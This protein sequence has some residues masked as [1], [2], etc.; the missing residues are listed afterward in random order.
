MR[1]IRIGAGTKM[2]KTAR[3]LRRAAKSIADLWRRHRV[4]IIYYGAV[5]AVL[6]AIALAADGYRDRRAEEIAQ[7][8]PT[9]MM[10]ASPSFLDAPAAEPEKLA[11]RLPSGA[12]ILRAFSDAPA[13]NA[14]LGQWE[15]HDGTDICY[16]NGD[17]LA[18]CAGTV[19]EI[20]Q[21]D[22]LGCTIAVRT[23]DDSIRYMGVEEPAVRAGEHVDAGER[24]AHQSDRV[25]CE[26]HLG[27][28]V[29]IEAVIDG[30][31]IDIEPLLQTKTAY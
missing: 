7:N 16:K 3:G 19:A 24:I 27:A 8:E 30:E 29:H 10:L 20:T 2:K 6:I 26:A 13:L 21:D 23:G 14:A 25:R 17:V 28:H 1:F 12:V 5:A 18:L 9:Q 31:S 15:A 11:P 4:G 22:H